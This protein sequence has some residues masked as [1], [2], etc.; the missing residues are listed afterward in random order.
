[1][2]LTSGTR[3]GSYEIV[4]SLGAGGM[5]EVYRAHDTNL[6]RAVALK[7]LPDRVVHDPERLARFRREA[8]L[9]AALNH[10]HIAGI[11]GLEES[12]GHRFIVLELVDGETLA[13]RLRRGPLPVEE[14][15]G[16]AREIAD[17]LQSA[18]ERG[19][20][21]RDL[22][23]AN[24]ALTAQDRVKILDFGLAKAVDPTAMDALPPIDSP[25]IT[26]PA[27]LTGMG[28]ILGTAAYMSPEQAKGRAAD[29]RSD[30]WAFGCVL[31]EMLT[32][33]RAFEG[34]EVSETVAS[35]LKS[36]PSWEGLPP[37]V[38]PSI[39]SLL[40]GCLEK[41]HRQRIA[42]ISTASFVLR[43]A[44]ESRAAAASTPVSS[45]RRV[46]TAAALIVGGAAVT[47]GVFTVLRPQPRAVAAPIARFGVDVAEDAQITISRRAVAISPDGTRLVYSSNG[48]L[49]S[50]SLADLESRPIAGADPGINPEFSPDGGWIVFWAE[51]LLKR[52][53]I[54][55][56]VP[57]TI[58]QTTPA[59]FGLQWT[60]HGIIFSQ[61][62]IGI[63]R[64]SPN[65]GTPEVIVKL[66]SA[67]GVAQG[68][69]L[70]AD[71]KSIIFALSS[72]VTASPRLW[73]TANIVQQTVGSTERTTLVENASDPR[74]VEP[75]LL[76][77]MV[78]GTVMAVRF[79]PAT[80][81]V[82]SGAVPIHE[83][84]RRSAPSTGYAGQ[85]D[86]S[87]TGSL[88]YVPGPSH[89]GQEDVYVYDRAGNGVRA[90]NLPRGSYAYP[91]V[92]P[93]GSHIAVEG[94]SAQ[95]AIVA[96]YDLS[97][98]SSLRRLTFGGNNRVP[99]WSADGKRVA[100]QSDRDGDLAIFWQPVDGGTAE[101]LTRP[102]KG[103]AHVP[104]SWSPTGEVFLFSETRQT[105]STLWI[106]SMRDRKVRQFPDV[107]SRA[108]PTNAT[109][110]P[111]GRWVA[112]QQG[113][114][115]TGE[116]V[117]YVQPFPPNGA[118][119]EISQGGRPMWS[120]DGKEIFFV[121]APSQFRSV[122]VKTEPVLSFSQPV[123]VLRRFGLAPPGTPRPYDILSDGRFVMV[124]AAAASSE[125]GPRGQI[126]VVLNWFEELN[127][128]MPGGR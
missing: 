99:I 113:D 79:D 80:R 40:E 49:Y 60:E 108:F 95:E 101:R 57:V 91:R 102:E 33:R 104:E 51:G 14:A 96:L 127:A 69:R 120:R 23:P 71:G 29:K 52:I 12:G 66:T 89:A 43:R 58:C 121:P 45:R 27:M 38:P 4:G 106:F 26:S 76:L 83:G 112:Y 48:K 94:R 114:G 2:P 93:D 107:R 122:S 65:S 98:A 22:K 35:V 87:R 10:P 11:Y 6:G 73:D 119:Y 3:L 90:L 105:E 56:G 19:I 86:V 118:K 84:V 30:V 124:D 46:L 81:K 125:G 39:R 115:T 85:Y 55:G 32:A 68:A 8:Q 75:G 97:G 44:L 1:M 28:M 34:D 61:P 116:A 109:F 25:T 7:T 72:S 24:I 54:T 110:S 59:P 37:S 21:H 123:P 70:L 17:A 50:R 13:D 31:F 5:G 128:R 103:V 18:H 67:E 9:L 53:P 82:T 78:E 100:F 126:N 36:Q 16:I 47:A 111:D 63:M 15:V 62:A 42:D 74:Y 41:D 77:Y 20:I 88:V 92:S 64:V 117:T